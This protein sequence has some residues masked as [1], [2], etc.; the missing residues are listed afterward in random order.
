MAA[1]PGA[2]SPLKTSVESSGLLSFVSTRIGRTE[3]PSVLSP[4]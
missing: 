1:A 3:P 4:S 2:K